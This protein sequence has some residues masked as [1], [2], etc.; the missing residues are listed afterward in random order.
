MRIVFVDGIFSGY[1]DVVC[2]ENLVVILGLSSLLLVK[3]FVYK[4]IVLI[5]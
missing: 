2:I 4:V 3:F 1:W 5:V